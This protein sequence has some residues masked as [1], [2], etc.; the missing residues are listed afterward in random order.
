MKFNALFKVSAAAFALATSACAS[1]SDARPEV[2]ATAPAATGPALW[3]LS[4]ED[5]T[6]YLF[7]TVHVLPANID[8]YDDRIVRAFDASD[9]LVTEVDTRDEVAMATTIAQNA[10]LEGGQTLR[11]LMN[12]QDRGEYEAVVTS[13]GLPPEALDQFEPWFAALN[14]GVLPLL[15]AGYDPSTGVE[16][17]LETRAGSKKRG[18]LET[19]EQQIDL[20]DGMEMQYQLEYLDS[21]VEGAGQTVVMVNEMVAEWLEG[22]AV[23]LAEIMNGEISDSYLYNRLLIDRNTNWV[24][25]IEQR[26]EQPG[27]VFVAVGAGH[28]AGEGS[29]QDQLEDRGY[30]VTRIYE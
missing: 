27:T 7:G 20:F 9:S 8:W 25:W 13:L 4:D 15:Q 5:T 19:V 3:Q 11:S 23:R 22:D 14:L 10:I 26:L 29:V 2:V 16:A 1:A 6:I 30:V 17:A 28:L 18:A 24:G 12:E 21:T